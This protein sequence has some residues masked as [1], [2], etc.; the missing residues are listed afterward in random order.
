[1]ERFNDYVGGISIDAEIVVFE[2]INAC[3][4]Y[5]FSVS[6]TPTPSPTPIPF[7]IQDLYWDDAFTSVRTGNYEFAGYGWLDWNGSNLTFNTG[8]APN[9]NNY[10]LYTSGNTGF[11]VVF[12]GETWLDNAYQYYDISSQGYFGVI[13]LTTYLGYNI[14]EAGVYL[15]GT[16]SYPNCPSPT[17]TPT[18]TPTPNSYPIIF[19]SSGDTFDDIC[20]NPQPIPTLYS[21]QPFFTDAQQLYYDSGLTQF[22][23]WNTT[24][25]F[26]STG[27]TQLYFYGFAPF[28]LGTYGITCPSPTPTP[29]PTVTSTPTVTP[30]ITP[31]KTPTPTPSRTCPCIRYEIS[32]NQSGQDAVYTY[33]ACETGEVVSRTIGGISTQVVCSR[34]LPVRV[35]GVSISIISQGPCCEVV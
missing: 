32:N 11:A 26:L 17:P 2:D 25:I 4:Y 31:T 33:T 24:T 21:P 13:S 1:M 9:S 3:D 15:D 12:S 27:G 35:S 8:S 19:V 30:T 6:P 34:V 5:D 22:I 23:D 7:C 16:I 20:S 29:T 28:G 10:T 14:P 18:L